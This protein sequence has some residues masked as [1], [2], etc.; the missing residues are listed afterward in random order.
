MAGMSLH[1]IQFQQSIAL[2]AVVLCFLGTA[3]A[4]VAFRDPLLQLVNRWTTREEYSHGFLIPVV[5]AWLIWAGR[6]VLRASV[7]R[8]VWMGPVIL[9]LATGM[10]LI[11][12]MGAIPILSQVG[13][14]VALIG[15]VL[16]VGGYSL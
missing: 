15:L 10:N 13:F 8:P 11:G 2:R 9:L 6:D 16:S 12:T 4:L 5:A 3:V 14:V 1:S 7:G